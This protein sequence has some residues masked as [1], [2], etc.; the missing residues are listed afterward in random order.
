MRQAVLGV[1]LLEPSAEVSGCGALC[2]RTC[3]AGPIS[4]TVAVRKVLTKSRPWLTTTSRRSG[5]RPMVRTGGP[6]EAARVTSSPV[7]QATWTTS[8]AGS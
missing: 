7:A 6:P 5:E 3:P 1:L 8:A 2:C 4:N